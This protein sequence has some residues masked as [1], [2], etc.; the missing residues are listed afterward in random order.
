MLDSIETPHADVELGV[1]RSSMRYLSYAPESGTDRHTG[2]IVYLAGY[3][4]DPCGG[5]A[6]SLLPYLANRHNCVAVSVD[7]FGANLWQKSTLAPFPDFFT[8]LA[9][10]YGIE[11]TAPKDLDIRQLLLSLAELLRRNGITRL[12]DDCRLAAISSEYNSMG[13]L[14]AL[15]ALQVVHRLVATMRLDKRRLFLIGTSYGGYIAEL[16]AKLAP[17]T[18][19]MVVDNSGFSSAADDPDGVMGLSKVVLGG[20]AMAGHAL[21]A[22]SNDPAK[23]NFFSFARQQIRDLHDRG[24]VLANTARI[25]AY[26][27]PGD[28]V[29]STEQKL[30]LRDS[31][32]G[33]VA[34]DLSIIGETRLDGRVFKTL[35]HGMNASLRGLFDLSYEKY[36]AD[37]GA[38][39]DHTDFDLALEHVFPCRGADY[40]LRYSPSGGVAAT[41]HAAAAGR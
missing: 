37:G 41:I 24:H 30:R 38:L 11:I 20:V 6:Q 4:M 3:G 25:Y 23:P 34:F 21:R 31:Y 28:G 39:A 10:H 40:R 15:D 12:H 16:M 1:Q 14:P 7:Y 19:R 33:R 22:W 13:L 8:R 29:A 5:Y 18:F 32:A 2:L 36:L 26:H 9:E 35:D 17:N 27:V